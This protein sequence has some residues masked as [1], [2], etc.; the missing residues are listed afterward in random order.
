MRKPL[1]AAGGA[2]RSPA[3][4]TVA[5]AAEIWRVSTNSVYRQISEGSVRVRRFG[6]AI[7]IPRDVVLG[8]DRSPHIDDTQEDDS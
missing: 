8:H 2:S 5:E 7:R 6:S 4:Y 1:N 3:F